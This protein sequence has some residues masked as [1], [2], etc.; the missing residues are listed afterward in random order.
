MIEHAVRDA[1]NELNEIAEL[2]VARA[3]EEDVPG[4]AVAWRLPSAAWLISHRALL[5]SALSL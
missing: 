1:A 2:S 4:W 3:P 5:E